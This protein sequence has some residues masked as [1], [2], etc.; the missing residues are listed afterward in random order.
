MCPEVAD[1]TNPARKPLPQ[2][3]QGWVDAALS[4]LL[5]LALRAV[6][7]CSVSS[8]LGS[9]AV[10]APLTME[11]FQEGLSEAINSQD[12]VLI[13]MIITIRGSKD[14]RSRYF[15]FPVEMNLSNSNCSE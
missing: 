3:G 5:A 10:W 1:E 12:S 7:F 2:V 8:D 9:S 13:I 4:V 14:H 11:L 15:R 6:R